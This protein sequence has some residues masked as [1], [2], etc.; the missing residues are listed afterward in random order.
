MHDTH[1]LYSHYHYTASHMAGILLA[2]SGLFLHRPQTGFTDARLC[3]LPQ[4]PHCALSFTGQVAGSW[5][6]H[7]TPHNPHSCASF[8]FF[9]AFCMAT[10]SASE[11]TATFS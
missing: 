8:R 9:E 6:W 1:C 11:R 3:T 10:A 5:H 7:F 4:P 2:Y